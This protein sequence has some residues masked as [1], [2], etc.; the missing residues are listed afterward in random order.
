MVTAAIRGR[1][2]TV[3]RADGSR[4]QCLPGADPQD[5][6]P[7]A[8][9]SCGSV[10]SPQATR[11]TAPARWRSRHDR[12]WACSSGWRTWVAVLI[13]RASGVASGLCGASVSR[14]VW[15]GR[16]ADSWPLRDRRDKFGRGRGPAC[17]GSA[18]L[19]L[20]GGRDG[21]AV[22]RADGGSAP[23]STQSQSGAAAWRAPRR[24]GAA[25]GIR[26]RTDLPG[27]AQRPTTGAD[28]ARACVA[29]PAPR[30]AI[31][32]VFDR[33]L[34]SADGRS[35]SLPETF[36]RLALRGAG[37]AV[38]PQELIAG[39]GHVDLLVEDLA[40]VEI[41]G[42]AYHG[43]RAQFR[44]DRRRDRALQLLGVP[45]LRFTYEDTVY[46]GDRLVAEVD[47]LLSQ[48][49]RAGRPPLDRSLRR[50]RSAADSQP[51]AGK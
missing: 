22:A 23:R 44:E 13:G 1:S 45:V 42:F 11:P 21:I 41:D 10:A 20:G 27:R 37:F 26:T 36:A 19:R 3:L 51:P 18:D 5:R 38:D 28:R 35:Q 34:R 39:V 49:R 16:P 31:A 6:C 47:S 46:G 15:R 14:R 24:I 2:S 12:A 48:L 33:L 40:V 43:D 50:G 9:R 32:I 8:S 25:L 4:P 29:V 17:V 30:E 7:G